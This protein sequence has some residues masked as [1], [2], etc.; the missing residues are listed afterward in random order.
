MQLKKVSTIFKQL[1]NLLIKKSKMTVKELIEKLEQ[2]D[3]NAEVEISYKDD[4]LDTIK[5]VWQT[6][7]YEYN[8]NPVVIIQNF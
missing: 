2:M 5:E 7:P 8:P 3:Q 4:Y 1:I 6:S